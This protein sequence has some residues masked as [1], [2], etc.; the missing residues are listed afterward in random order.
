MSVSRSGGRSSSYQ[1]LE[2]QSLFLIWKIADPDWNATFDGEIASVPAVDTDEGLRRQES[3][4]LVSL[5][6]R[7][8]PS[9]LEQEG[10]Q[11]PANV[12]AIDWLQEVRLDDDPAFAEEV[13][14]GPT[15]QP[16]SGDYGLDSVNILSQDSMNLLASLGGE[17]YLPFSGESSGLAGGGAKDSDRVAVDFRDRYG[18]GP[19]VDKGDE[20]HVFGKLETRSTQSTAP[21][22][23]YEVFTYLEA[24]WDVF[25]RQ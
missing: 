5:D 4:E 2:K 24:C 25:D 22:T 13:G 9:W 15:G 12:A 6:V 3:A 10:Q 17:D 1:D 7:S 14:S 20:L 19:I 11:E 18:E 21:S 23:N 16:I 8:W